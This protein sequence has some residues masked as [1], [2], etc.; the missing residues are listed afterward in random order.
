M[1]PGWLGYNRANINIIY[2]PFTPQHRSS[3][4]NPPPSSRLSVQIFPPSSHSQITGYHRLWGR[5]RNL[6]SSLRSLDLDLEQKFHKEY[7]KK[8]NKTSE[9]EMLIIEEWTALRRVDLSADIELDNVGI[10]NVTT[11]A[12]PG[13][14]PDTCH[15]WATWPDRGKLLLTDVNL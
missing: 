11:G 10:C 7:L 14:P 5:G 3:S 12:C 1:R 4:D 13:L 8:V 2:Q 6:C 9:I 15:T